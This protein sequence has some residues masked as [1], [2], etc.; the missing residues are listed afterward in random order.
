MARTS[1]AITAAPKY[2]RLKNYVNGEFTDISG[3]TLSVTSPLDGPY[4]QICPVPPP[5][6]STRL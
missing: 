2:G 1:E 4:W 5:G 3:K 6:I